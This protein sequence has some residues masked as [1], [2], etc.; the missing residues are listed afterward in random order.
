MKNMR[1]KYGSLATLCLLL[2]ALLPASCIQ[3]EYAAKGTATVTMTFTTRA[4][5]NPTT[6]AVGDLLDN[7]Q[8]R[9]LRVIVARSETSEICIT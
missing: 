3:D 9:T 7:E 5:S 8:M 4:I 6:R 2:L 1:V